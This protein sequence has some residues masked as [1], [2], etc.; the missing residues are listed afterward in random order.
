MPYTQYVAHFRPTAV[1][2]SCGRRVR[3]RHY[4]RVLTANV[5]LV[6][7]LV[8][9][10]VMTRSLAVAATALA[11]GTLLTFLADFWTFKN[12]PWDPDQEVPPPSP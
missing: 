1:C 8:V 12:L 5:V 10:V 2:G 7:L 4:R 9:P 3:L 11:L 6:A